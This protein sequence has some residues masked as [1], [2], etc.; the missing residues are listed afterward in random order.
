MIK[1]LNKDTD[2]KEEIKS[3]VL[4]DFYADWCAPCKMLSEILETIDTIDILKVN[5]DEYPSIASEY[6]I[7]SIPTLMIFEDSKDIKKSTGLISKQ[8]LMD[9]IQE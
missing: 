1:Y 6:G 8:E 9:F 4:V 5:V 3:R 2:F 7:M